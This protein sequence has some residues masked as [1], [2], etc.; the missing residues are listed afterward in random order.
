[1]VGSNSCA[2]NQ[3]ASVEVKLVESWNVGEGCEIFMAPSR[4]KFN[5]EL[6]IRAV[7]WSGGGGTVDVVRKP[8]VSGAFLRQRRRN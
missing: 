3:L 2:L 4:L 8:F 6:D 7:P 5:D 1:M